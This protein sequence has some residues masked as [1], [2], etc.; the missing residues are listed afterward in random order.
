MSNRFIFKGPK[1]ALHDPINQWE[2]VRQIMSQQGPRRTFDIKKGSGY[3]LLETGAT[4]TSLVNM[5]KSQTVSAKKK[6]KRG[7]EVDLIKELA[8]QM[9]QVHVKRV[10]NML[11]SIESLLGEPIQKG[12][13]PPADVARAALRGLELRRK[14]G[15]GGLDVKQ[16]AKHGIGSGVQRAVNLKNRDELSAETV[17]RMKSF[18][19]RHRKNKDGKNDKGEPSA[20]AIAWLLWGGDAGDRWS[21]KVVDQINKKE[22]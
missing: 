1:A 11:K 5:L 19:A 7:G 13:K 8:Q 18:F 16:A 4:I 21:S 15:R 17:K 3:V 14:Y 20:G 9:S 6:K 22:N 2:I 10:D 12:Y